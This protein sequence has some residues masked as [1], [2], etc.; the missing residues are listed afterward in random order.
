VAAPRTGRSGPRCAP[1]LANMT[2]AILL[3][4]L[5][6]SMGEL[7]SVLVTRFQCNESPVRPPWCLQGWQAQR[8]RRRCWA[9]RC[10]AQ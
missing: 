5:Q 10:S 4:P 8:W 6:I 2:P 9:A 7:A 1:S 3:V